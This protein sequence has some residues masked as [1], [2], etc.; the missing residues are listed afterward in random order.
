MVDTFTMRTE[1]GK[2]DDSA[3]TIFERAERM[4]RLSDYKELTAQ[5]EKLKTKYDALV[6]GKVVLE[7]SI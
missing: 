6:L 7:E 5:Y 3:L 4:V 1:D 2:T